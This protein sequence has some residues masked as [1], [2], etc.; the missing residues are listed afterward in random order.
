MQP[1]EIQSFSYE[2]RAGVLPTLLS[3]LAD[4][5]GWVL[6]RRSLSASTVEVSVEAQLRSIVELYGSI[7]AA[8]LE[9]TRSS[10]L[11]LTD[12]CNCRKYAAGSV[13]LGQIVTLRL[14]I[15]FLEDVSIQS[16]MATGVCA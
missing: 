16:L 11:V 5:G 10:H 1:L 12:L 3:A 7:I 14:E 15:S 2:D 8:G 13:D 9:L 6:D 4:G